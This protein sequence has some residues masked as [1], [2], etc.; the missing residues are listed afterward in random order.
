MNSPNQSLELVVGVNIV[1]A[2]LAL[3]TAIA[4]LLRTL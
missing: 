3:V 2:I 4:A 1:L